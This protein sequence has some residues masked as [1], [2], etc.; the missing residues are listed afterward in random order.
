MMSILILFCLADDFCQLLVTRE[1]TK[2]LGV[3]GKR[4][5]A[6]RLSLS[7]VMTVRIHFR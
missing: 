5:P 1:N 2:L 7:E 4:G 3:T 6:P